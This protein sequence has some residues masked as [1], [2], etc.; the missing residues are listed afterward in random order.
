[1]SLFT[2]PWGKAK[3]ER[4]VLE[5]LAVQLR[6]PKSEA[7]RRVH[8]KASILANIWVM[9]WLDRKRI[10]HCWTCPSTEQLRRVGD[11]YSC[12]THINNAPTVVANA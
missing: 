8:E 5:A 6:D 4:L 10:R 7:S 12:A 2:L 9:T 11:N 3:Q 1:M